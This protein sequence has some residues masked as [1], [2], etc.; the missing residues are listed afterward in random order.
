MIIVDPISLGDTSVTRAT[1]AEYYDR[2]GIQ[3]EAPA[4]TLCVTYDPAD[5]SKAPYVLFGENEV[6]SNVP[7]LVHTNVPETEPLHSMSA[8]YAAKAIVRDADH[9]LYESLT[10]GN[11]GN[12]LS[13]KTKW[14]ELKQRSN[15]RAMFDER[16]NTQTSNPDEILFVMSARAIAQGLYLGNIDATEI[17]VSMT[18]PTRGLVYSETQSLVVSSTASS[19]FRWCFN[20]IR[21]KTYFLTLRLPVYANG[22]VTVAI[23]KPGSIAKCGMCMLG[24]AV[25]VGLSHYGL[26]TEIKDF[27]TTNFNPDGTSSTILRGYAKRMSVDVK[28]DNEQVDS[29]EEQ[30]IAYRQKV[31]VWVGTVMYGSAMLCGKYSSFRKVISDKRQSQ[32]ALQ[33][34]GVVS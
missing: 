25:D 19:F 24:P 28:V 33:I 32:M 8:T 29:V 4:N 31:V 10:A 14:L 34:E 5:L 11:V 3:Q 17:R 7:G 9:W 18:D 6:I 23:L 20:R 1:P 13:D 16:N 27:S 30:L 22:L 15:P 12:A 26:T 2:A 21:R